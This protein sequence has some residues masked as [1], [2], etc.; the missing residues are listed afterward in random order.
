MEP[1]LALK[2][3]DALKI[4]F[5][6]KIGAT[7]TTNPHYFGT[8]YLGRDLLSRIMVGARISLFIGFGAPLIYVLIGIVY[9]ASRVILA[10]LLMM[11]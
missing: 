7:I 8:D 6:A 4:D 3:E 11:P 5:G 9:G 2:L 1:L 10:V